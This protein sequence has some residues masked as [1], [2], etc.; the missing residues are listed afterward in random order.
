MLTTGPVGFGDALNATNATRLALASRADGAVLKPAAAAER[1][2]EFYFHGPAALLGGDVGSAPSAPARTASASTD[3]RAD[4]RARKAGSAGAIGDGLWWHT[5]LATN[6]GGAVNVSAAQLWPPI[7]PLGTASLIS[8]WGGPACVNNSAAS[9]CAAL[10]DTV[11]VDTTTPGAFGDPPRLWRLFAISP[12]L[13]G[14]WV[15]L[16]EEDKY[17]RVSP[18]RFV[19]ARYIPPLGPSASDALNPA[20]ELLADGSGF[21]VRVIGAPF[22]RVRVTVIVPPAEAENSSESAGR[23]DALL[24]L[25]GT[26]QVLDLPL[27]PQGAAALDCRIRY[28]GCT[29]GM[30][31][32]SSS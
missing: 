1:I 29:T 22:E 3:T 30:I 10:F 12:V 25:S 24:A 28:G 18:Q 26:A 2:D 32:S 19:A 14:G 17:V 21:S 31:P 20:S 11:D 15:L 23:H 16:G 13:P 9:T 8:G 27:G 4:S 6:V 5:L 7:G